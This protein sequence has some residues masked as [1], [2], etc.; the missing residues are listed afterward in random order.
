MTEIIAEF[1]SESLN[2]LEELNGIL[3]DCEAGGA[4]PE[5]LKT[6][7]MLADRIMGAAKG[8]ALQVEQGRDSFMM[9][10]E[11]AQLYKLLGYKGAQLEN[12]SELWNVAVGVML[13]AISQFK[14][15]IASVDASEPLR[16]SRLTKAMIDRLYWLDEQF[17]SNISGTVP[18]SGAQDEKQIKELFN[19]LKA[20]S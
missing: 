15:I 9:I 17:A 7:G 16:G 2:L 19:K 14:E 13:D 11:L 18:M 8:L 1:K 4:G 10:G 5:S 20:K 6:C 3:D 12:K